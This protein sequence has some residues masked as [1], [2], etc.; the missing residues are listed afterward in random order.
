[1]SG[2][3]RALMITP[4]HDQ[5]SQMPGRIRLAERCDVDEIWI[6]QPPDQ[7]DALVVAATYLAAARRARVATGVVPI[8]SRHP[9]AMA[10]AAATLGELSGGRFILGLG[11]G[12]R[13]VAEF[14]LGQ[15]DLPPVPATREYLAIVRAL[16]DK[17]VVANEGRFFTARAE[18]RPPR[19]RVPIYLAALRPRMIRL[20]AAHA[21][22]IV[23]YLCTPEVIRTAV[24]PVLRKA[25]AELDRDPAEVPVMAVVPAY[26]GPERAD[27]VA[28]MQVSI[29][30]YSLLP[31]YR[32]VLDLAAQAGASADA[33]LASRIALFGGPDE[34]RAG[35]ERY[36]RA[37]CVPVPSP[38]PGTDDDF[39]RTVEALY[40]R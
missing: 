10:Q 1:M 38:M 24:L 9:V 29:N 30:G 18:Y 33:D 21:D 3:P 32:G 15:E 8:R 22:G 25:C 40:G 37:G 19:T 6:D 2:T 7:R 34:I 20:A 39:A 23:L 11:V 31:A 16:L 27:R 13:F 36:R 14:V 4:N 5:L 35:L 26:S 17:G 28:R 12:H